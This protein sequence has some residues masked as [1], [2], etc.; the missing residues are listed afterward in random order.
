MKESQELDRSP[1]PLFSHSSSSA[2]WL[3]DQRPG[4]F[5]VGGGGA[6]G[7]K[8]SAERCWQQLRLT[9]RPTRWWW[10]GW[11][12]RWSTPEPGCTSSFGTFAANQTAGDQLLIISYWQEA[13]RWTY[14]VVRRPLQLLRSSLYMNFSVLHVSL[15]AICSTKHNT[16]QPG[17]NWPFWFAICIA[18]TSA[19]KSFLDN[20]S[21]LWRQSEV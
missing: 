15:D 8:W 6:W 9:W 20:S 19:A 18:L 10:W 14:L 21:E 16:C 4:V 1:A 5:H 11:P 7:V 17:N 2:T 12:E 13:G 3:A